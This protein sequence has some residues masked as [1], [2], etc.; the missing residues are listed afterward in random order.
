M[1][2]TNV[3]YWSW[4]IKSN[5]ERDLLNLQEL[6]RAGWRVSVVWECELKEE[7]ALAAR[8]VA[9]LG[10]PRWKPDRPSDTSPP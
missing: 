10:Q 1:P 8:L 6:T 9:F 3:E 5:R 7:G 4:K 2:K